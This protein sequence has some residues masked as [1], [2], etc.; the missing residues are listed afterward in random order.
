MILIQEWMKEGNAANPTPEGTRG[1][2]AIGEHF[3]GVL[4]M[5]R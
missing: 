2:L 1:I 5:P 3:I 4:A